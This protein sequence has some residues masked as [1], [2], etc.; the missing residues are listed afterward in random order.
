MTVKVKDAINNVNP[1][2]KADTNL[3]DAVVKMTEFGFGAITVVN[4][5]GSIK[6]VFTD[7]GLRRLISEKGRDVLQSKLGDL[8]FNTPISIEGNLL[9]NDASA[10]FKK[11]NVDTIL[12]TESGK[13]I[14]MLDI[15]DMK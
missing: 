7:G 13:P 15:Q 5:D 11:S 4:N 10:L 3:I 14:G 6:G 1:I 12:V 8:T 2:V 9:L